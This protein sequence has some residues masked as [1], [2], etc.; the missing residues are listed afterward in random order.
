MRSP[1]TI[2]LECA[3]PGMEVFHAT[4]REAPT[5]QLVG[6]VVVDTP[7]ALA[8][9]NAG[10]FCAPRP[11]TATPKS[12]QEV[13]RAGGMTWLCFNR[14]SCARPGASRLHGCA[15]RKA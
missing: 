3:S 1:H 15:L 5:S 4:F 7:A 9:R 8:P 2:G 13:R 11:A 12:K 6:T 14:I 10:Q